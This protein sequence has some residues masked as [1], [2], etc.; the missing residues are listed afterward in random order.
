MIDN[1]NKETYIL[2]KRSFDAVCVDYEDIAY[3][4]LTSFN[5]WMCRMKDDSVI[6]LSSKCGKALFDKMTNNAVKVDK[7]KDIRIF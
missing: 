2:T 4:T 3:V 1:K 6:E 7:Y 5:K